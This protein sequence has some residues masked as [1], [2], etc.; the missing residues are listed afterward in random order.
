MRNICVSGGADGADLLWGVCAR[1]VG[2]DVHHISFL[3]HE[4][5]APFST[6]IRMKTNVLESQDRRLAALATRIGRR[7]PTKST[8]TDNL[9]RRNV[10]VADAVNSVYA[11][12]PIQD[13]DVAGGTRWVVELFLDRVGRDTSQP[14][15][16]FNLTC[17][18]WFQWDPWEDSNWKQAV[19]STP[20]GTYAG[21]GSS[22]DLRDLTMATKTLRELYGI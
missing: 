10:I 1:H 19:P 18:V 14:V 2:H 13:G 22:R 20:Q 6:L 5:K 3:S 8:Y 11:L 15:Y 9:L 4:S 7:F 16:V 21:V 17:G 12:A